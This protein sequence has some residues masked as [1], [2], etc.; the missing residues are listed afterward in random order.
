MLVTCFIK[1]TFR[2]APARFLHTASTVDNAFLSVCLNVH[3]YSYD[4]RDCS[5]I[6]TR[7]NFTNP[8]HTYL[9]RLSG[10]HLL[11]S[12]AYRSHGGHGG[13]NHRRRRRATQVQQSLQPLSVKPVGKGQHQERQQ[14]AKR[15]P[16]RHPQDREYRHKRHAAV[17]RNYREDEEWPDYQHPN[18][19]QRRDQPQTEPQPAILAPAQQPGQAHRHG[20]D[21][22]AYGQ[23]DPQ[24]QRLRPNVLVHP[25]LSEH[26]ERHHAKYPLRQEDPQ[27]RQH[28]MLPPQVARQQ[29]QRG[30][31]KA[32]SAEQLQEY[33][34]LGGR[35]K[36]HQRLRRTGHASHTDER[37]QNP[38]SGRAP[39]R[40]QRQQRQDR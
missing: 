13:R 2:L 18:H 25:N 10:I 30:Q 35:Q 31:P 4:T 16:D 15:E 9:L 27:K 8:N 34:E 29:P 22:D 21:E 12:S 17:A 5:F 38:P 11:S 24:L 14:H 28:A 26:H 6:Q 36:L 40:L 33:L 20:N 3:L 19:Y 1:H 37:N 39:V 7:A 32:Q 23:E